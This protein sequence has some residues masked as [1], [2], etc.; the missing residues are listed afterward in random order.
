MATTSFITG[1]VAKRPQGF[2]GSRNIGF[3]FSVVSLA[4]FHL[5]TWGGTFCVYEPTFENKRLG[6]KYRPISQ[7]EAA[8]LLGKTASELTTPFWYRF[9]AGLLILLASFLFALIYGLVRRA[10]MRTG[11]VGQMG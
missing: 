10:K 1:T 2:Y 5:W 3:K 4:C 6:E 11:Q 7:A 9:P 8:R